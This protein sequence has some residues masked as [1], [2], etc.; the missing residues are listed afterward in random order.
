[1]NT[2]AIRIGKPLGALTLLLASGMALAD[3]HG[4]GR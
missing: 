2:L 3:H 4:T 1:M